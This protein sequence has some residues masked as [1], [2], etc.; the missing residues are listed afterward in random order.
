MQLKIGTR[1]PSSY[2]SLLPTQDLLRALLLSAVL[3]STSTML[4]G[5][6]WLQNHVLNI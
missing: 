2:I 5:S 3:T 6:E 1:K 4:M